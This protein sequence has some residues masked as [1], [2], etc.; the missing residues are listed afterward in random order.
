M[1][2]YRVYLEHVRSA[3]R[4]EIVV[5]TD[6]LFKACAVAQKQQG[7]DWLAYEVKPEPE[8]DDG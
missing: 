3:R 1:Q 6:D 4:T 7:A 8:D 5:E 2:L